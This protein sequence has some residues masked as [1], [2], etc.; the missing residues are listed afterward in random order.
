[1]SKYK[2]LISKYHWK[3]WKIFRSFRAFC[4]FVFRYRVKNENVQLARNFLQ[5]V[6]LANYTSLTSCRGLLELLWYTFL[7]YSLVRSCFCFEKGR[8]FLFF[9]SKKQKLNKK[10]VKKI[11]YR[12]LT[13]ILSA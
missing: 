9:I 10:N 8:H 7:P 6:F 13:L 11:F 2:Y 3:I 1:M 5:H 4:V 12:I